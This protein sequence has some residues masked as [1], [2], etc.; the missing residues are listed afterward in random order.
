[1]LSYGQDVALRIFEPRHFVAAGSRPTSEF[2]V[3]RERIL[4][5]VDAAIFEPGSR[6]LD[7]LHFPAKDRAW[8]WRKI[9][10]FVIRI[11]WPPTL[12]T[13]AKLLLTHKNR[14]QFAFVESPGVVVVLCGNE[15]DHLS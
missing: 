9:G 1:M 15:Y 7:V 10:I 5:Q 12:I 14:L 4:F 11:L 2:T 13:K 3:W 8:Q 6:R